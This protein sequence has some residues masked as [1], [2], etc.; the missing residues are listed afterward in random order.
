[1]SDEMPLEAEV[2]EGVDLVEAFLDAVLT[3]IALAGGG[4]GADGVGSEGLGNGDEA[5]VGREAPGAVRR[6]IDAAAHGVEVL[7]NGRASGAA[8]GAR[9]HGYLMVASR[10]LAVS[11]S[12][13]WARA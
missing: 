13:R 5:D 3:E 4:R 7:L 6:R 2:G 12:R 10:A 11:A 1:M 9:R 8:R